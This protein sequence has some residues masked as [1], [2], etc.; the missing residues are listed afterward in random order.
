MKIFMI[1]VMMLFLIGGQALAE[2]DPC[3]NE[4][5]AAWGLCNAYCEGMDCD[6]EHPGASEQACE[7]VK[8]NYQMIKCGPEM[9]TSECDLPCEA[10]Q[11]IECTMWTKDELV[12][13]AN[14]FVTNQRIYKNITLRPEVDVSIELTI[15]NDAYV[16]RAIMME[17]SEIYAFGEKWG[18]AIKTTYKDGRIV[19]QECRLISEQEA[20]SCREHIIA[21]YEALVP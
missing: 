11:E 8:A 16:F 2:D 21:A 13:M 10:Q 3:V 7:K 19:S 6:S 14:E 17:N 1:L 18:P 20:L 4:V 5:G 15:M 9:P 12:A